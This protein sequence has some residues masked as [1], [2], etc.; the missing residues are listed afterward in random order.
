M[1]KEKPLI[2]ITGG[3][4]VGKFI[5]QDKQGETLRK[6]RRFS[7][8][9]VQGGSKG[10][11][12]VLSTNDTA[13]GIVVRVESKSGKRLN[14][15]NIVFDLFGLQIGSEFLKAVA[16]KKVSDGVFDFVLSAGLFRYALGNT[17]DH[18]QDLDNEILESDKEFA[19]AASELQEQKQ[20]EENQLSLVR[21]QLVKLTQC[22]KDGGRVVIVTP[23]MQQ[24]RKLGCDRPV[25]VRVENSVGEEVE[26]AWHILSHSF[27]AT[28]GEVYKIYLTTASSSGD[29][30]TPEVTAVIQ[31]PSQ[32]EL[33]TDALAAYEQAENGDFGEPPQ[34]QKPVQVEQKEV[35][36]LPNFKITA[37]RQMHPE[38]QG[39]EQLALSLSP[40]SDLPNNSHFE[41]TQYFRYQR[42]G[43]EALRDASSRKITR[44]TVGDGSSSD[45][46][47]N[48]TD[49]LFFHPNDQYE[50]VV[51][52]KDLT[53]GA[54]VTQL[55][56]SQEVELIAAPLVDRAKQGEKA[57]RF[58]LLPPKFSDGS[59]TLSV[60]AV[61]SENGSAPQFEL[62]ING[63]TVDLDLVEYKEEE[64]IYVLNSDLVQVG[65]NVQLVVDG[66][67]VGESFRI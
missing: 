4:A 67:N 12:S 13:D 9:V 46:P 30:D 44:F 59:L 50:V 14:R 33:N 10:E 53:I 43:E 5:V 51:T 17:V 34:V 16:S 25:R 11:V 37:Q 28:Q 22:T 48:T 2:K 7:A 57:E 54:E 32:S 60:Q 56:T 45:K 39:V 62:I 31:I 3:E 6:K 47:L 20:E 29:E 58:T 35:P 49:T 19:P 26:L 55:V 66:V 18:E 23:T 42:R 64:R 63:T 41:V 8:E 15:S 1:S 40:E 65:D 36:T 38:Q 24:I 52:I 61:H 21:Q 27:V